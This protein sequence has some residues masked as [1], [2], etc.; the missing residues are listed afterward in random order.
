[1]NYLIEHQCPQCGAPAILEETERLFSCQF[2][3]VR[4]YLLA[5][6][7]FRYFF[8]PRSKNDREIVYIPYWR[9]KGLM[10]SGSPEGINHRFIDF[11]SLAIE[12]THFSSSVGLRSQALK[13]KF[14]P[15]DEPGYFLE[16]SIPIEKALEY[17][18][19]HYN[20]APDNPVS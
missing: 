6:K 14:I 13:L 9:F 10:F 16:P 3:R 11:S 17:A 20:G 7:Y 15:P 18:E 4:S 5:G 12:S 8:Q 19:G 1:M 2:C